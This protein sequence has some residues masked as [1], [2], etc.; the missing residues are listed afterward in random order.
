MFKIGV[1]KF[2]GNLTEMAIWFFIIAM[3]LNLGLMTA[4]LG[5]TVLAMLALHFLGKQ[6]VIVKTPL[7]KPFLLLLT[8][9]A[10][11]IIMSPWPVSFAEATSWWVIIAYYVGYYGIREIDKFERMIKVLVIISSIMAIYSIVQHY[12]GIDLFHPDKKIVY[13]HLLA[14]GQ[15]RY[16]AI[17]RYD[18]HSSHAFALVFFFCLALTR[19]LF[20]TKNISGLKK[21]L[22]NWIPVL[23]M[24]TTIVFT[25]VRAAWVGLGAS[26]L[27]LGIFLDRK[28]VVRLMALILVCFTITCL[29]SPS[30]FS[31]FTSIFDPDYPA[32]QHRLV[33][34]KQSW[35]IYKDHHFF[36]IGYGNFKPAFSH[37]LDQA[38]NNFPYRSHAHNLYLEYLVEMGPL[39]LAALFF[40]WFK[41]FGLLFRHLHSTSILPKTRTVVLGTTIALA[42]MMVGNIAQC[43]YYNGDVSF[44]MWFLLGASLRLTE[45][46][47]QTAKPLF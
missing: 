7:D 39:G 16:V 21:G 18:R 38:G 46:P 44:V 2:L 30:I 29:L 17:G 34:W 10:I 42:A 47:E 43:T 14:E 4:S 19:A 8:I 5:V 36:G 12:T 45:K 26:F 32:N 1:I 41:I 27:L 13:R 9:I 11:S 20:S 37:Y 3:P 28:I 25:Y 22:A 15:E 24:G 23:V 40:L 6:K 35:E 31:K 33:I